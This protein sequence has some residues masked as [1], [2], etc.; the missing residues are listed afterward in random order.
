M[1]QTGRNSSTSEDL[2]LSGF[3]VYGKFLNSLKKIKVP[4]AV[5]SG[6]KKKAKQKKTPKQLRQPPQQ[7]QQR[8]L[9]S[10]S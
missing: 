4:A 2:Y 8:F 10:V 9:P 6:G 5:E 7:Q 1:R 3:E